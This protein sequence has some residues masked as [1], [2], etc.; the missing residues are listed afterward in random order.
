MYVPELLTW[1][2]SILGH[3][4]NDF[5]WLVESVINRRSFVKESKILDSVKGNNSVFCSL[6]QV[7]PPNWIIKYYTTTCVII[8]VR[9]CVKNLGACRECKVGIQIVRCSCA[10]VVCTFDVYNFKILYKCIQSAILLLAKLCKV[11]KNLS[12]R[13]RKKLCCNRIP[14]DD[15]SNHIEGLN[16][17]F[18]Q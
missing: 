15:I 9:Y 18:L 17:F 7:S 13:N 2:P 6:C 14:R 4:P 3:Y 5:I 16:G 1:W 11:C 10:Y 12:Y 8:T